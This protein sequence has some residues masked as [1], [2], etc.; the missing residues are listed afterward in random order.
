[1]TAT[2]DVFAYGASAPSAP[3]GAPPS[4]VHRFTPD[5]RYPDLAGLTSQG[6]QVGSFAAAS[7]QTMKVPMADGFGL[8]VGPVQ[9]FSQQTMQQQFPISA[10]N[11]FFAASSRPSAAASGVPL[12]STL[13]AVSPP[14]DQPLPP[15][16]ASS[17][18]SHP[19]ATAGLSS[20]GHSTSYHASSLGSGGA[21]SSLRLPQP[22]AYSYAR[23]PLPEGS[24]FAA[25]FTPAPISAALLPAPVP[26]AHSA[27]A[28]GV[29]Y[30]TAGPTA[31]TAPNWNTQFVGEGDA[32]P[33]L[34][35]HVDPLPAASSTQSQAAV[36]PGVQPK[37]P[38]LYER[39]F[40]LPHGASAP[41]SSNAFL[42]AAGAALR[43]VTGYRSSSS[44]AALAPS[45]PT[46][47]IANSLALALLNSCSNAADLLRDKNILAMVG[48]L[49]DEYD[50]GNRVAA[51]E[52]QRRDAAFEKEVDEMIAVNRAALRLVLDEAVAAGSQVDDASNPAVAVVVFLPLTLRLVRYSWYRSNKRAADMISLIQ[53]TAA[54]WT[55]SLFGPAGRPGASAATAL[56]SGVM[57]VLQL[58]ALSS[59][60]SALCQQ[61]RDAID[62]LTAEHGTRVNAAWREH[63][64]SHAHGPLWLLLLQLTRALLNP[65]CTVGT[66]TSLSLPDPLRRVWGIPDVGAPPH[67][68]QV[69]AGS[70][71]TSMRYVAADP[72]DRPTPSRLLDV[73]V[74][75]SDAGRWTLPAAAVLRILLDIGMDTA[76]ALGTAERTLLNDAAV[77]AA[78]GFAVDLLLNPSAAPLLRAGA[79]GAAQWLDALVVASPTEGKVASTLGGL[80]ATLSS[81]PDTASLAVRLQSAFLSFLVNAALRDEAQHSHM[82]D[83]QRQRQ[84]PRDVLAASLD[85]FQEAACTTSLS[86]QQW[87]ATLRDKLG[88][89]DATVGRGTKQHVSDA[90][91]R[92]LEPA[93]VARLPLSVAGAGPTSS[94][95]VAIAARFLRLFVEFRARKPVL[96]SRRDNWGDNFATALALVL[97]AHCFTPL[98]SLT[99]GQGD[100][101][102][103]ASST[104][105]FMVPLL[106]ALRGLLQ[107]APPSGGSY[108]AYQWAA[109]AVLSFCLKAPAF[110]RTAAAGVGVWWNTDA[111]VAA[112]LEVLED[113]AHPLPRPSEGARLLFN[114]F[115]QDALAKAE[116]AYASSVSATNGTETPALSPPYVALASAYGAVA[117]AVARNA[118]H[119]TGSGLRATL[120]ARLDIAMAIGPPHRFVPSVG[121]RMLPITVP[122]AALIRAALNDCAAYLNHMDAR[123]APPGTLVA[124]GGNG[125]L[126]F[127]AKPPEAVSMPLFRLFAG[128]TTSSIG[129]NDN[130]S[131]FAAILPALQA[132]AATVYR[133]LTDVSTDRFTR[134]E[135]ESLRRPG[136]AD[137]FR[138]VAAAL[139]PFMPLQQGENVEM[140]LEALNYDALE[141]A[142]AS[143]ANIDGHRSVIAFT[144]GFL[145]SRGLLS[146]E[147]L[148]LPPR[149]QPTDVLSGKE[150]TSVQYCCRRARSAFHCC[151]PLHVFDTCRP[152]G[153]LCDCSEAH[154]Y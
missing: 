81:S 71:L 42:S 106:E 73:M 30:A 116:L 122:V 70:W 7:P 4:T 154:F 52:G 119:V 82:R 113:R 80:A 150:S 50:E 117:A 40:A 29:G 43:R 97:D 90:L 118:A 115:V 5:A 102:A 38:S 69:Y 88:E 41:S 56:R 110:C 91:L 144:H 1:V 152:L 149:G 134:S 153:C 66:G 33:G 136:A 77:A 132:V 142:A 26:S 131:A 60:Q 28:L 135:L 54:A 23:L 133:A 58:T 57:S 112:T 62:E 12:A 146:R 64:W 55:G 44:A 114:E 65:G 61:L 21:A 49:L 9:M 120:D 13:Y 124:V 20:T 104:R 63:L 78:C 72:K 151:L 51:R 27:S 125:L 89:S 109:P 84:Q 48:T 141:V 3:T 103:A 86:R 24:A 145:R 79:D 123:F 143:F 36:Q 11:R 59:E 18:Y 31:G 138:D 22:S 100:T 101:T 25:A 16:G 128:S 85:A 35:T 99:T 129:T 108:D 87:S 15:L 126:R 34:P 105:A 94:A 74:A 107:A 19:D 130:G 111:A 37:P 93:F 127:L 45:R 8:N 95:A 147:A 140:F 2:A 137:R 53:E 39:G 68:Q 47:E 148:E 46:T 92:R 67:L 96:A 10:A 76:R 32:G 17:S 14:T 6:Q 121:E 139:A 98:P 83:G 75:V